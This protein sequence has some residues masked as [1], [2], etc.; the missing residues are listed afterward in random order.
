MENAVVACGANDDNDDDARPHL[1][2]C[3]ILT[4]NLEFTVLE[5]GKMEFLK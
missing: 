4:L 2:S 5:R 1:R 3:E